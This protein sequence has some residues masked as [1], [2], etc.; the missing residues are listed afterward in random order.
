MRVKSPPK[1]RFFY[2]RLHNIP[3]QY[4][5]HYQFATFELPCHYQPDLKVVKYKAEVN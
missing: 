1:P 4:F 2:W 3:V 5:M